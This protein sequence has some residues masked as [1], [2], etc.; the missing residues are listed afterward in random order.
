MQA[1]KIKFLYQEI[2]AT[3]ELY[4]FMIIKKK[5]KQMSY[6]NLIFIYSNSRINYSDTFWFGFL[7][8]KFIG[9]NAFQVS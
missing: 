7:L 8:T 2:E 9:K 6:I 4:L 3:D 1:N 5:N